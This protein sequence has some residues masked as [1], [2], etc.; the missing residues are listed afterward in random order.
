MPNNLCVGAYEQN[1][2]TCLRITCRQKPIAF[3]EKLSC[4]K[5]SESSR[6]IC[7]WIFFYDRL[8]VSFYSRIYR[9]GE[10]GIRTPGALSDTQHFQCCTIGH[11]AISPSGLYFT[12]CKLRLSGLTR[13]RRPGRRVARTKSLACGHGLN[14]SNLDHQSLKK[15]SGCFVVIKLLGTTK[16]ETD[17]SRLAWSRRAGDVSPLIAIPAVIPIYL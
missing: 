5:Q 11:S 3:A 14:D 2:V 12:R 17:V 1:S 10:R 16:P 15:G 9:S 4:T 7:C 8:S 13:G 6:Y